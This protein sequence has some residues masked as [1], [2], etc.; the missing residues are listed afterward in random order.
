MAQNPLNTALNLVQV[1]V[2]FARKAVGGLLGGGGQES[3]EQAPP[4]AP[5]DLDDATVARK[6][7]SEIFRDRRIAKGK[8]DVNVAEGVVWLRGEARTPALIKLAEARASEVP[9]VHKVENLLHLP[10][11]PAPSRTDTPARE[12]KSQRS[13][14]TQNRSRTPRAPVTEEETAAEAEP[15]PGELSAR[16]EGRKPP[17]MGSSGTGEGGDSR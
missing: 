5:K 4:P 12:R 2:R 3:A 6:V 7:E 13:P 10:K 15:T 1:P 14:K 8:I 11:T 9:E 16:D 17:P